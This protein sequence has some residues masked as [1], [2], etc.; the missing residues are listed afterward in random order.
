MRPRTKLRIAGTQDATP[1]ELTPEDKA[2]LRRAQV[3]KAQTQHRQRKANYVRQLEVD[4]ARIRDMIEA[5]QRETHALADENRAMREQLQHTM[6]DRSQPMSLGQGVS[7]PH[8]MPPLAQ[9]SSDVGAGQPHEEGNLTVSLGFDEVMGAP[10][11]YISSSPSTCSEQ[12]SPGD[13]TRTP[14]DLPDLTPAETHAA[15]NFILAYVAP[16]YFT[17]PANA[18]LFAV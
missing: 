13:T 9:P 11:F 15:I 1:A 8:E 16:H 4:I 18:N 14:E 7:L 6:G 10:T 17:L 3:R 2:K 12:S 5:A